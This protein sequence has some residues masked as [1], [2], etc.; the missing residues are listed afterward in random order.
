M[1]K[2]FLMIEMILGICIISAGIFCYGMGVNDIWHISRPNLVV[3]CTVLIG[4]FFIVSGACDMFSRKTKEIEIEEKDER[5]IMISNAAMAS[6]FK[7]MSTLLS[8]AVLILTFAG[9]MDAIAC[10]SV[11]GVYFISQVVF[12]YRLWDLHKK[13]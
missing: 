1:K 13:M 7:T 3:M 12:V 11:I 8:V 4:T 2:K 10:L 5:N 9:F 6:G